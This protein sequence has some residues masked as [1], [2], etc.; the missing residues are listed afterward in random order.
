HGGQAID[1]VREALL[2]ALAHDARVEE[3]Q[4]PIQLDSMRDAASRSS[5]LDDVFEP[6]TSPWEPHLGGEHLI[7]LDGDQSEPERW[8]PRRFALAFG[9]GLEGTVDARPLDPV[10]G[11][12]APVL[13]VDVALPD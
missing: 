11:P 6:E 12:V 1:A 3:C 13:D 2:G 5:R 4:R 9:A 7:G 8:R 10:P